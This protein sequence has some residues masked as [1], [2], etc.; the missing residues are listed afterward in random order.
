MTLP[1]VKSFLFL[2]RVL[3]Q[4]SATPVTNDSTLQNSLSMPRICRP[5]D[6]MKQFFPRF[7]L[8]SFKLTANMMKKRTAQTQAP[9]NRSTTSGYVMKTK[10]GPELTT[11]EISWPVLTARLPRTEKVTTPAI[12]H[13]NVLTT[14]VIMASLHE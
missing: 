5:M 11:C 1:S 10:P 14:H 9:G 13:V 7:R 2:L 6:T 3:G 12:R 8:Q 4:L